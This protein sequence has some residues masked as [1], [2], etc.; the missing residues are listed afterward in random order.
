MPC[1]ADDLVG[2]TNG[3]ADHV[4]EDCATLGA[5][6]LDGKVVT[7]DVERAGDLLHAACRDGSARACL[8]LA[9]ALHADAFK[10]LPGGKASPHVEEVELLVRACDLGANEGCLRAGRAF[11][12]AHGTPAR[13]ARAAELFDRACARGN[14]ASCFELGR[15]YARGEGVAHLPDRAIELFRRACQ[16]GNDEGCLR[17]DAN[18]EGRSPRE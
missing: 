1:G 14:G 7:V 15:L 4:V 11:A 3:C 8:W 6:Y 17:A 5:M 12:A 16:L 9:A 13:P 18:G 10:A 2:C